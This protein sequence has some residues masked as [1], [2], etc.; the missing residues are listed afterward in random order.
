MNKKIYWKI[1]NFFKNA[2]FFVK[3]IFFKA[4]RRAFE[5]KKHSNHFKYIIK[6]IVIK[7]I[8]I[9]VLL[10]CLSKLDA[11]LLSKNDTLILKDEWLINIVVGSMGIAGVILGLY[12]AN[13]S[14]I[15]SSSYSGTIRCIYTS[16][17]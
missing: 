6:E 1:R 2:I 15:S 11:Y 13:I 17:R 14:S 3:K 10:F 16:F 8:Y 5:E 7:T 4:N 12:Y 9:I